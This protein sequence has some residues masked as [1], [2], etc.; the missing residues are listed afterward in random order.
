[1]RRSNEHV[2]LGYRSYA[3]YMGLAADASVVSHVVHGAVLGFHLFM[4]EPQRRRKTK[5]SRCECGESC[6]NEL[7]VI[8]QNVL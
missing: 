4:S 8:A 6:T 5:V 3:G 1:M 2:V 7:L